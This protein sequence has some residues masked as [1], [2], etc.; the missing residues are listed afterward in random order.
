MKNNPRILIIGGGF[1]G[2]ASSHI[3]TINGFKDVTL[4]DNNSYL[5]SGVRTFFYGG[6]PY[7]FGPRH[8]LTKNKKLY[9][10]LNKFLPMRSCSEHQFITYIEQ[11]S[12]FYNL[13]INHQDIKKMPDK[14]KIYQ[15]LK[16]IKIIDNPENLEEYWVNNVGIT[17]Y[18]KFIKNYNEKMWMIDDIKKITSFSWSTKGQPIQE[19]SKKA[20]DDAISAYPIAL[21]G[22][23]SYFNLATKKTKVLLNTEAKIKDIKKK[24]FLINNTV[25]Q[26]DVVISS[27]SPDI[28]FDF[29]F[30]ELKYIGRDMFNIV[31]PVE[32]CLPKDVYFQYFSGKEKHTRIVEYKK[33]TKYKSNHTLIGI[34]KPSLNGKFYPLPFSNQQEL[35]KKYHD[36]FP[37]NF[38]SIGRN[39]TYRYGVDI[40]DCIEQAFKVCENLQNNRWDYS[41]PLEKHRLKSFG[42]VS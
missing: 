22:Y 39:G 6:H 34:E 35:A 7:T 10:Y 30:G 14:N 4:I 32:Y 33:L 11:D 31:L 19:T 16:N 26:F 23:N 1:A 18:E 9:E 24:E 8:F 36:E 20:F 37:N 27:I 3:L 41:I 25:Q 40:D 21:D 38:Y 29:K 15:E 42:G 28:F 5:G 17:L 13:P 2:C 12:E